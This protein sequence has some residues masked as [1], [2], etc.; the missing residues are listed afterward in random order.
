MVKRIQQIPA[1]S[2]DRAIAQVEHSLLFYPFTKVSDR[3]LNTC[4]DV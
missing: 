1:C 2:L 3:D 4:G